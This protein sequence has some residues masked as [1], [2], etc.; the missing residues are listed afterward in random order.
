MTG[1]CRGCGAEGAE[2]SPVLVP[3]DTTANKLAV[4]PLCPRCRAERARA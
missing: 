3:E 2:L 4:L 1:R